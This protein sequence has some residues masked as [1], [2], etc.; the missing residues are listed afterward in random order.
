MRIGRRSIWILGVSVVFVLLVLAALLKLGQGSEAQRKVIVFIIDKPEEGVFPIR[1][2]HGEVIKEIIRNSC[3]ACSTRLIYINR[4]TGIYGALEQVLR[5]ASGES[6]TQ[7]APIL[8]N[9]SLG[10]TGYDSLEDHVIRRLVEQGVIVVVAAG[11]EGSNKIVYPA[12]YKGVIA[13]AGIEYKF[14]WQWP[15]I[16]PTK[17]PYSNY[18]SNIALAAEAGFVESNVDSVP[19]GSVISQRLMMGSSFAAPRVVGLLGK[20]LTIDADLQPQEALKI[21]TSTAEPLPTDAYFLAGNLGAGAIDSSASLLT[22]I[23]KSPK[24]ALRVFLTYTAELSRQYGFA[25]FILFIVGI[26]LYFFLKGIKQKHPIP[27]ETKITIDGIDLKIKEEILN[28]RHVDPDDIANKVDR[29]LSELEIDVIDGRTLEEL[30]DITN[31]LEKHNQ[32]N[33]Y[34]DLIQRLKDIERP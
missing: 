25:V 31:F 13:V 1:S 6:Q 20:L 33:R 29:I 8:V 22:I 32:K 14:S 10:H 11:N 16:V 17:A 18:G 24:I 34:D 21:V 28:S 12:G 27:H 5:Y 4:H 7:D 9:I 19:A 26:V 15:F 30:I 2:W 3:F 23:H